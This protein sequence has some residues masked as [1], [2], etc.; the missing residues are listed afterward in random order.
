[1]IVHTRP[2]ISR[3]PFALMNTDLDRFL[4]NFVPTSL[5]TDFE[6]EMDT[7]FVPAMNVWEDEKG[8]HVDTELPGVPMDDVE[9]LATSDTITI[10]GE[11]TDRTPENSASHVRER[12]FGSFERFVTLPSEIEPDAVNARLD[13]GVLHLTAPK[14]D[15][16]K[17]P[18]KVTISSNHREQTTGADT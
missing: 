18:R 1:M 4:T 3:R 5:R 10:K 17:H 16:G 11:H 2:T 13:H 7:R 14:A 6:Q 8:F 15:T 12:T 9:V